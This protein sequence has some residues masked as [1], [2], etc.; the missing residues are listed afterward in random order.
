MFS[1][2]SRYAQIDLS[3]NR[4]CGV[5]TERERGRDVR[6][7]GSYTAEGIKAIADALVRASLT[8]VLAF[9]ENRLVRAEIARQWP[10]R[11]LSY[12]LTLACTLQIN[13]SYNYLG[14]EGAKVLGPAIAVSASL[15]EVLAF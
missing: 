14:P 6:Q 4:L 2:L 13:L 11:S 9:F 7:K 15:T 12:G 5:W 3:N 8:Q 10:F 1:L